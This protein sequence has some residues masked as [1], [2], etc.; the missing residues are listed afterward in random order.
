MLGELIVEWPLFGG[1]LE[2]LLQH[3]YMPIVYVYIIQGMQINF[4]PCQ[5]KKSPLK[6]EKFVPRHSLSSLRHTV[7]VHENSPSSKTRWAQ[8]TDWNDPAR[9]L[10]SG[11]YTPVEKKCEHN[12]VVSFH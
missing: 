7:A 11:P 3:N 2:L 1:W 6:R 9:R 10:K 4:I 12:V 5:G 8:N